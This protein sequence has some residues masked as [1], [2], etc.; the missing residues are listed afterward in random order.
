MNEMDLISLQETLKHLPN[1]I[2]NLIGAAIIIGVPLV[3]I[4]FVAYIIYKNRKQF[5]QMF[6]QI[7]LNEQSPEEK[8]AAF[9]KA[10]YGNHFLWYDYDLLKSAHLF[11]GNFEDY[12]KQEEEKYRKNYEKAKESNPNIGSFEEYFEKEVKKLRALTMQVSF[13]MQQEERAN[14]RAN[15]AAISSQT[16][17]HNDEKKLE[18]VFGY[19]YRDKYGNWYKDASGSVPIPTP[20]STPKNK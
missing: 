8:A 20:V 12:K 18:H 14:A 11:T 2:N 17:Y 6:G 13:E 1:I 3:V 7:Y 5:R 15:T 16:Q 19:G 4:G 10:Q 9:E